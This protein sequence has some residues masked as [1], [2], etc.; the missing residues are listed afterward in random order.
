MYCT[1]SES[2]GP[3]QSLSSEAIEQYHVPWLL[4]CDP[5]IGRGTRF[6]TKA[7]VVLMTTDELIAQGLKTREEERRGGWEVGDGEGEMGDGHVGGQ[8]IINV[9]VSSTHL[10]QRY[11]GS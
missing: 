6:L 1:G 11:R 2:N 4:F 10:I 7:N 8:G 3:I 5:E 9:P